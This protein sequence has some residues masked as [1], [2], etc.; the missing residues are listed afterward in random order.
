[1]G[2]KCC[3]FPPDLAISFWTII[4][5]VLFPISTLTWRVNKY[6]SG[7]ERVWTA[8]M[9]ILK[10]NELALMIITSYLL[11]QVEFQVKKVNSVSKVVGIFLL[12]KATLKNN[13][14]LAAVNKKVKKNILGTTQ[15]VARR[16]CSQ[17]QWGVYHAI[18]RGNRGKSKLKLSPEFSSTESRTLGVVSKLDEFF[19][20]SQVCGHSEP[21]L[22]LPGTLT[23]KTRTIR[24]TVPRMILILNRV[25]WSTSPLTPWTQ[26]L[27]K[28]VLQNR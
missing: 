6:V 28:T 2:S 27:K 14:E 7:Q 1:M 18:L 21:L 9:K 8:E 10:F 20:N 24:R 3:N 17:S 15:L 19:L 25:H 22:E 23:G 5:I 12:Q 11:F 13:N 16:K 26:T 4:I